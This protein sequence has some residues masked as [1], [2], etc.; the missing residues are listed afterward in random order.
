MVH[1]T[2]HAF[3]RF[4]LHVYRAPGV[5]DACLALQDDCGADV[6]LLLLCGWLGQQGRALDKRRLRQAMLCIDRWQSDVIAPVRSAR[7]AIKRH[8]PSDAQA[9][10]AL[11]KQI[12][13]LELD[14]EYVE[15]SML[16]DLAAQWPDGARHSTPR[17]AITAS[18][19]RYMDLLGAGRQTP[20]AAAVERIVDACCG[21]GTTLPS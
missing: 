1:R 9:A 20:A 8:P 14:L 18:L 4:S 19:A 17:A 5:Q 2:P 7:R 3:W 12:L 21:A 13:A 16:A 6:N 11:R 15:Q 10:Q